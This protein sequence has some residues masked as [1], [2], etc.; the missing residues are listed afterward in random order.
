MENILFIYINTNKNNKKGYQ[1]NNNNKEL[2]VLLY[3]F[4]AFSINYVFLIL[5]LVDIDHDVFKVHHELL[6]FLA[7][8]NSF[9][10]IVL[11]DFD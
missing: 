3:I 2:N 1:D 9:G 5:F 6:Q 4:T 10:H 7:I 8:I 11:S